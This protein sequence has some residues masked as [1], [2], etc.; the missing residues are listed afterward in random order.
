MRAIL[1]LFVLLAV[2]AC[3]YQSNKPLPNT[4]INPET[5]SQMN[6]HRPDVFSFS[7]HDEVKIKHLDLNLEVNF[8]QLILEGFVVVHYDVINPEA[9]RLVL[10]TRELKIKRV[11]PLYEQKHNK[12][13]W[14]KGD[15]IAGLGTELIINIPEDHSPIK[16]YYQTSPQASG[17]QWLSPAQTHGQHPYL[18]SQS[19]AI[20][21]RSWIPIQDTPSV[22]ITYNAK[23]QVKPNL[24]VVMSA[25]NNTQQAVDGLHTFSMQQAIPAYLIAIAAGDIQYKKISD[26]VTVFAQQQ[27]L[28]DAAYE[29]AA[30]EE[31]ISVTEAIY[32]EYRWGQYDLLVLPPSFPFGGMENPKLSHI[33]PTIIAGDRSLDSLIAHE[34]AHSWSG[35]LVTN[36]L[37]QDAWLNEGFTSYLESRIVEAVY[38]RGRMMMEATLIYDA[39]LAEMQQLD[40]NM[41][42]LV[43]T[44]KTNDPDDFFSSVAYDKGRFFLEWLEQQFG[45]EH[46]DRFLNQYFDHFAFQSIS[47]EDFVTFLKENLMDRYPNTVTTEQIHTWL[48]Q[49]AMPVFFN[50]P[51]TQRFAVISDI[52]D[53]WTSGKVRAKNIDTSQW[54]TQEWLHFLRSL[55]VQLT[56]VQLQELDQAFDLTHST[57][58]EI[59]HDWLLIAINNRYEIAYPRL[60]DYL[61]HIGRVKLIKP[62]YEAM[63]KQGE[64][65][66]LATNIY[67]KARPGYH[68]IAIQQIDKIV[69]QTI[70]DE[71]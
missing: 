4:Q 57:N 56:F 41:Q 36:A 39:M 6:A 55:P 13:N 46:F 8:K 40:N 43:N 11:E 35:N 1:F 21:A 51:K 38:G 67:Q 18:F 29:F 61:T 2:T 33:T 42:K 10:D 64:L 25:D 12:L 37:W 32:G 59:S 69:K 53:K 19:Q 30:T 63:M 58:S 45:R 50:P 54:T 9:K 3:Q 31:M 20:H 7:R 49:P 5:L 26:H 27:L 66:N 24:R 47:T 14:N 34:L 70:G 44:S 52:A 65:I 16:I 71:P 17:L 23:I 60:I 15:S 28:S 22:R 48:H 68:H 62:L